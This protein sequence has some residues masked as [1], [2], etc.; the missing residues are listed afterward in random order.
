M[1]GL[2]LAI[3]L[4]SS[5]T[6]GGHLLK[7]NSSTDHN[8]VDCVYPISGQYGFLPRLLYYLL[9]LFA[10]FAEKQVWLIAGAGAA[11]LTYSGQAAIHALVLAGTSAH[12]IFDLDALGIYAI[13]S[14]GSLA[15]GIFFGWSEAL[16]ESPARPV[17]KYWCLLMVIGTI[18]CI[19][20]LLR[21]Y[22]VEEVCLSNAGDV[23]TAQLG[24]GAFNCTY[25]CFGNRQAFRTNGEILVI[26]KSPEIS[27][28]KY[29]LLSV[30][31]GFSIAFGCVYALY[32]LLS[33]HRYRTKAELK[34]TVRLHSGKAWRGYSKYART[35]R[36]I[37]QKAQKQLRE[38]QKEHQHGCGDFLRPA[39]FLV[40][41][42]L[43]EVVLLG[44]TAIPTNERP[45]AVGQ[46]APW[47][48]VVLA[49]FA[50]IVTEHYRPEYLE[51]QNILTKEKEEIEAK[52]QDSH[53]TELGKVGEGKPTET[54]EAQG[55]ATRVDSEP[56]LEAGRDVTEQST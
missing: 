44:G 19:T 54:L 7:Y 37:R 52:K 55:A 25:T 3:L 15:V 41:L 45:A 36:R 2:E 56:D 31:I 40:I 28:T 16:R 21:E 48:G 22:P 30:S 20:A 35:Q 34:E 12:S 32:H 26:P 43:N 23:S 47:V 14:T 11:A 1:S 10:V 9:L 46:W 33:L 17:F 50:S 4:I 51:R 27:G 24:L 38:G 18:C 53:K 29:Q 39:V 42:L 13:V 8:Q 5:G 6:A 49:L